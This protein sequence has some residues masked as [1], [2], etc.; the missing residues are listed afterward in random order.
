VLQPSAVAAIRDSGSR[1]A[2]QETSAN[3]IRPTGGQLRKR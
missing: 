3:R 1:V 2:I